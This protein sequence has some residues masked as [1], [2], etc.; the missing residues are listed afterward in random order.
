MTDHFI[1]LTNGTVPP[2]FT[3]T[4]KE[5]IGVPETKANR[6]L[7][8]DL[9]FYWKWGKE[10][11]RGLFKTPSV[12]NADLTAP[13]MHNG[14]Y[15]TLNEVMDFYNKGGGSGLGFDLEYQT[16]PF[17]ELNLSQEELDALVEFIKTLSDDEVDY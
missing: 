7:D 6:A 11:H 2:F 17:D 1:P 9:G 12:R 3:E 14:V 8:D 4:E 15:N 5:V 16:L 10:I 13:Y